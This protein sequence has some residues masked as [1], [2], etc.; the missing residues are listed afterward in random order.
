MRSIG[1]KLTISIILLLLTASVSLGYFS[2]LNS[3]KAVI[4]QV[5]MTLTEKTADTS[6]YIEERF[7]RSAIELR[8]LASSEEVRSMDDTKQQDFLSNELKNNADYLTFAII[9][10]DGT[11]HYLDGTTADLADRNYVID[12]FAGKTTM[13]DTIISRV[14][15][16]PVVMMATPIETVTNEP[17]LLLARI[18]GYYLSNLT[19]DITIGAQGHAFIV[20][21]E[22]TIIAHQNRDWVKEQVN[23]SDEARNDGKESAQSKV[24]DLMLKNNSGIANYESENGKQLLGY[25]NLNNGWKL[26]VIAYE[27]DMLKGL[28]QLKVQFFIVALIIMIL[29]IL[30][31]ITT[32][33]SV[34]R[35][36]K[37]V[38]DIGQHLAN[39]DFTQTVPERYLKR[40]DEI[41]TLSNTLVHITNNMKNMIV[42]VNTSAQSVDDA[43]DELNV[44]ANNVNEMSHDISTAIQKIDQGAEA[45]VAMS[46]ESSTLIEQMANGIQNIAEVAASIATSTDYI[47]EKV[48]DGHVAVRQSVEQMNQIQIGTNKA[49]EIIKQLDKESQE[50]GQISKMITD[51]SE[52]TNLLALNASIEAA[53]AGDAGKGFA[54]VA[55]E[56]RVLSEQTA[57]SASRINALIEVVQSHTR[58]AVAAAEQGE[59]NVVKGIDVVATLGDRFGDIIKSIE[60][61]SNEIEEMS[62]VSEEMAAGSQEVSASIDEMAATAKTASEYVFEVTTATENQLQ[63]VEEMSTFTHRLNAMVDEL[64]A[65]IDRF[66]I[67]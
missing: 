9:K 48:S 56:V 32:S 57:D 67:S 61:V 59:D 12:A 38:V 24:I 28:D 46:E 43:A 45:Q 26:G 4:D 52:Q 33:L 62:A 42:S 36:I 25:H 58:E 64:R 40:H 13:S 6:H 15:N 54:V 21:E 19:D 17:A 55:S 31:A 10:E 16:E 49:T 41:G 47:T 18:D 39:G 30:L 5:K 65:S 14:T 11:S 34:S 29:G 37:A 23:F 27:D 7:N 50:I 53:R 3:S 8:A 22:G 60:E 51:I 20:N 1:S 2:Y 35:P 44:Q 66:K 63:T